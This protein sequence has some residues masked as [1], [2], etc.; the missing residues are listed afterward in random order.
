MTEEQVALK[1]ATVEPEPKPHAALIELHRRKRDA[2]RIIEHHGPRVRI[3]P[4]VK[5]TV[6]Q[7]PLAPKPRSIKASPAAPAIGEFDP[8]DVWRRIGQNQMRRI[9]VVTP[10]DASLAEDQASIP[11][12]RLTRAPAGADM[13]GG[14]EV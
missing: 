12:L 3:H 13:S 7:T 11:I 6:A 1:I 14:I 8:F 9:A 2:I 10:N 4:A 5:K